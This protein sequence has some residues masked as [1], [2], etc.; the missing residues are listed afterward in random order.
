MINHV[1]GLLF[2]MIYATALINDEIY[3]ED[4]AGMLT[5]VVLLIFIR[6]I[7]RAWRSDMSKIKEEKKTLPRAMT[8]RWDRREQ[9]REK[10]R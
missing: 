6:T 1:T 8:V 3:W 7:Y 4:V 10:T 9:E 5:V 2:G